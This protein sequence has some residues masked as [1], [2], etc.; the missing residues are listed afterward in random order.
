MTEEKALIKQVRGKVNQVC[1]TL[2][3]YYLI[4]NVASIFVLIVDVGIHLISN[5]FQGLPFDSQE[6][7]LYIYESATNNGWGY[8]F[9]ITAGCA[10]VLLWKGKEFCF[11]EIFTREKKMTP[12]VF[13]VLLCVFIAPQT[14]LQFVAPLLEWLLNM[15]GFSVMQ[16]LE[17]AAIETNTVSMFLYVCFL[18]PISEELLFRG[19]LLRILRPY[20]KK[21]AI[22]LPA[23]AFGLFHGN[24]IQAPFAF[25]VGLVMGY[26][27]VEYSIVW[28]M[29]L[30]VFNNFILSDLLSRLTA[31]YPLVG[32]LLLWVILIGALIATVV[33]LIV[34]R[35]KTAAYLRQKRI[36]PITWKGVLS[37]P[38]LWVFIAIMLLLSLLTITRV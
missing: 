28:A 1:T 6:L 34:Y 35:K 30:H 32:V 20:G 13:V 21:I 38:V 23:I 16:A 18:G 27:T 25:L 26:V 7:F 15:M 12:G 14:I 22:L 11:R 3:V 24:V 19:L 5:Y 8:L 2:L 4:M 31:A 37:A 10:I 36:A 9:A 29:V 17:M 33:L